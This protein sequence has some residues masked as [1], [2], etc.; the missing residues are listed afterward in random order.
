LS[1][2]AYALIVPGRL[3]PTYARSPAQIIRSG[4]RE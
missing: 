2:A 4:M 1:V 3:D